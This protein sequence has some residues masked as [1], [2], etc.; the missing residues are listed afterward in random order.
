[1][2]M[3]LVIVGSIGLIV[4]SAAAAV[5]LC[6]ALWSLFRLAGHP[7]WGPPLV[8]VPVILWAANLLP[9]NDFLRLTLVFAVLAAIPFCVE[10]RAWRIA[11]VEQR[12]A[13]GPAG[14][15]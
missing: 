3:L 13:T 11:Q 8:V 9:N 14:A 5:L 7:A 2:H 6:W 12:R 15:S 4:G 1:M 10:G